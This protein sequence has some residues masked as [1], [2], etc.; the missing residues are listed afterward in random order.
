MD[1]Q[2]QPRLTHQRRRDMTWMLGACYGIWFLV[3]LAMDAVDDFAFPRGVR[4]TTTVLYAV[5]AGLLAKLVIH[6]R[7]RRGRKLRAVR[8]MTKWTIVVGAAALWL[9]LGAWIDLLTGFSEYGAPQSKQ[10]FG[11]FGSLIMLIGLGGA[12]IYRI[13]YKWLGGQQP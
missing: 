8:A 5:I 9:F 3:I 13:A 10:S 2:T 7:Y 6:R 11:A 12:T 1:T 4:F